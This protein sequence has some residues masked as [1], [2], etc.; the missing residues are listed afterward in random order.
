MPSH[1]RK[2]FIDA[3]EIGIGKTLHDIVGQSLVSAPLRNV[4][5]RKRFRAEC[6][7]SSYKLLLIGRKIEIHREPLALSD[8]DAMHTNLCTQ[9]TSES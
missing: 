4:I 2:P 1:G 5:G 6:T 9:Y 8:I 3:L 7:K